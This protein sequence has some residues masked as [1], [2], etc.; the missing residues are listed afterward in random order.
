[1]RIFAPDHVFCVNVCMHVHIYLGDG[2]PT[3]DDQLQI[4]KTVDLRRIVPNQIKLQ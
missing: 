4:I 2:K 1:M 3:Y